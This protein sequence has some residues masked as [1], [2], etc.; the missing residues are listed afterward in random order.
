MSKAIRSFWSKQKSGITNSTRP[1]GKFTNCNFD[2]V[3]TNNYLKKNGFNDANSAIK[4][5]QFKGE[6]VKIPFVMQ[7]AFILDLEHPIAVGNFKS[8]FPIERMNGLIDSDLLVFSKGNASV[9]LSYKA[10]I[11]NYLL[12]KPIVQGIV[13]IKGADVNYKPRNLAFKDIAV[14]LDFRNNDLFISNIHL[15]SGKS[16]VDM[17]GDIRNFLNLYYNA[18]E[19]IVLNWTVKSPQLHLGEFLGF[20]GRRQRKIV[21]QK[22]TRKGNFTEDLN[23]L[24]EKSNVNMKI[25]VAKLY[26]NKFYATNANAELLLTETGI[27]I[28]KAG[29]SHAGG[30]VNLTGALLQK[31]SSSRFNIQSDVNNVDISK[32]FYAFDNFNLE[33]LKSNNLKGQLTAKVAIS[34]TISDKGD[35]LRRSMNGKVGFNLK[36]GKL[37][38]FSPVKSVGKFAFPFRKLDTISFYQLKGNFDI[39]GEKVKVSPMKINS[40]L[41][42]MDVD[43]IYSFGKGTELYIA[44]PLRNPE[45]DKNISDEEVLAKRRNRG[46]VLRLVASDGKDGKVKIG[47]GKKKQ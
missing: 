42:N 13:T 15:R 6:Y 34:G 8:D 24:F 39:E 31:G 20:L 21:V 47:F 3:F 44:V 28:K 16:I 43:G 14:N 30:F 46:I 36:D 41:L 9:N 25:N 12:S 26:Y 45:K 22:T 29:L 27:S 11:V 10:D 32:F 7:Q 19:R 4:L 40:S 35:L 1:A 17:N 33:S 38:N 18:P 23:L 2:G 5:F 37:I